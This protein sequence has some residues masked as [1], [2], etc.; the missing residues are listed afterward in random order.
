EAMLLVRS[1]REKAAT[2]LVE[3]SW[4]RAPHRDLLTAYLSLAPEGEDRLARV[5]R[6]ERLHRQ[7]PDHPESLI[8]L[9]EAELDAELW[10]AARS[11]LMKAEAKAPSRR[12]YRLLA[13]LEQ[14]E[15]NDPAAARNWLA[16]AAAADPD[17]SWVCADC[18]AAA[19]LWT[20]TCSTCAAFDTLEWRTPARAV[21]LPPAAAPASAL[22]AVK[23]ASRPAD[24]QLP[25]AP[26]A[27]GATAL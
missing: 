11:H 15:R 5:K 16:K 3:R 1:G 2:K 6:V 22:P 27:G 19:E 18:G 25:V 17:P 8:A 26:A 12:V 24:R 10:G 21:H 7:H 9:A 13:D 23:T 14:R 4:G 20:A